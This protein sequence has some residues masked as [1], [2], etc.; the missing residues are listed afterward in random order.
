MSL[1]LLQT[2]WEMV[3]ADEELA[4]SPFKDDDVI[5]NFSGSGASCHLTKKQL[6]DALSEAYNITVAGRE[7]IMIKDH[8]IREAV[9]KLTK[10]AVDYHHTQ[11]LRDRISRVV[12]N[13]LS[14][15]GGE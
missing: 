14:G 10:T 7:P 3:K 12:I 5:L 9:N 15:T 11:Q 1:Q 13:L 6:D 4:G 2:W 8:I